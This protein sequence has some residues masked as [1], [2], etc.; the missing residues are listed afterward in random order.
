MPTQRTNDLLNRI[1]AN[2]HAQA[3]PLRAAVVDAMAAADAFTARCAEIEQNAALS[4]HGKKQA[5]K[6][7]LTKTYIPALLNVRAPISKAKSHLQTLK[8]AVRIKPSSDP[9]D[10]AAALLRM[11]I[12]AS[13]SEM[14]A[15]G[16]AALVTNPKTD[17][18]ILEAVLTAP[19]IVTGVDEGVLSHIEKLWQERHFAAE[20]REIETLEEIVAVAQAAVDLSR[21]DMQRE[22]SRFGIAEAVF[23][24]EVRPIEDK[25]AA[26]PIWLVKSG[27]NALVVV[28]DKDGHANYRPAS[29]SEA[30]SG[31]Y[32]KDLAEYRQAAQ[33][34]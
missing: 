24:S 3:G 11:E 12:R 30:K 5:L 26:I 1:P 16:R 7:A 17:P 28:L 31:V 33:A 21:G 23:E 19:A 18:R 10:V 15:T 6:D 2:G 29:E 20:A 13:L 22:S 4:E 8:N 9:S 25:G 34:A 14:K 32:F 27:D